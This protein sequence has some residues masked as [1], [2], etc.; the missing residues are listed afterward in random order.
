MK[1]ATYYLLTCLLV[2][3]ALWAAPF[4]DNG[5]GTVTDGKTGLIWQQC[6]V[7]L[8]DSNCATGSASTQ[9]WQTALTTC[10]GLSL[11]G[12]TWR[13]PS[14]NEL[15]SIVDMNKASPAIDT[16]VFPATVAS[17]YWS[18]STSVVG[19]ANAWLVNFFDGYSSGYGAKAST[20]YVRCVS[21]P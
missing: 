17:D 20:N 3:S 15:L 4:T 9:N 21:G 2:S 12:K 7:G 10:N 11:A 19:T 14:T 1:K 6:T 18:S 5:N 13:L 8:S 16:S